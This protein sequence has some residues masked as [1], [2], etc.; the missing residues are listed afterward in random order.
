[1]SELL[2]V[3]GEASG[4]RAAAGVLTALASRDVRAFGMG[5]AAMH[6]AGVEL[7]SDLRCST[8]LGVGEVA[9]RALSIGAAYARVLRAAHARRPRAAL[10]VNYT[11]FNTR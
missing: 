3:A 7:V 8:A 9:A 11:A 10:L 4:D 6:A 5:G 2:V 1:M